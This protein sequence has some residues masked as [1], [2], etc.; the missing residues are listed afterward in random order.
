MCCM[1][2]NSKLVKPFNVTETRHIQFKRKPPLQ[3]SDGSV[4]KHNVAE[5]ALHTDWTEFILR[6]NTVEHKKLN[7]HTQIWTHLRKT[8]AI[9]LSNTR[10]LANDHV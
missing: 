4:D 7:F 10:W 5:Q 6:G 3:P 9:T 8:T 1:K 2:T